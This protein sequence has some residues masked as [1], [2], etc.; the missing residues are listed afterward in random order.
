MK[1]RNFTWKKGTSWVQPQPKR[2]SIFSVGDP[3]PTPLNLHVDT[4]F[5]GWGERI[6]KKLLET[7]ENSHVKGKTPAFESMYFLLN[8][9]IFQCHLV[10]G[11]N[12]S[13]GENKKSL[14]PPPSHVSFH[15]C[16]PNPAF[17]RLRFSPP[18][19]TPLLSP[20]PFA[21][22]STLRLKNRGVSC[23]STRGWGWKKREHDGKHPAKENWEKE[24]L[25]QDEPP[26]TY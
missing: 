24:W 15:G 4:V 26:T 25:L 12:P 10:G 16:K 18:V 21:T 19:S 8:M 7:P 3:T 13:R 14:K 5:A 23:C 22:V 11:F 6:S 20:T 9:G 2:I 17:F 1:L